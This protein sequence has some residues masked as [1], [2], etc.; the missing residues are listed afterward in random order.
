MAKEKKI[1]LLDIYFSLK[2]III[3]YAIIEIFKT[4]AISLSYATWPKA[5]SHIGSLFI[6]LLA[7]MDFFT[8]FPL[9]RI[10]VLISLKHQLFLSLIIIFIFYYRY[11]LLELEVEIKK[12]KYNSMIINIFYLSIM[13][14]F[15]IYYNQGLFTYFPFKDNSFGS[16]LRKYTEIITEGKPHYDNIFLS[17]SL[18]LFTTMVSSALYYVNKILKT[19]KP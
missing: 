9:N 1:S 12:I 14:I 17:V 4:I 15:I 18:I 6:W 8:L 19:K 3:I 11:Y 10:G 7:N 13:V 5:S 16:Y 2:F